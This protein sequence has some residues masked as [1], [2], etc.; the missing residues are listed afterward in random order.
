[1]RC[2]IALAAPL[3]GRR[4]R[5]RSRS[6]RARWR[7]P[8]AAAARVRTRA[9]RRARSRWRSCTRASRP[10]QSIARQ[11]RFVLPVRNVG[12]HTVPNVAVT[13]DSFDYTSD[14]PGL[15]ADKRPI[16]AIEQGPGAIATPP[17]ESQ[18]VSPPGGGQTAYVNTWALGALAPGAT[19]TFVW[20]VVPVKAGH[21][22]RPLH[23]RSRPRGQGEGAA[24]HPAASCRG[25]SPSTSPRRP[26]AQA[27]QPEHGPR[28]SR[29]SSRL[30]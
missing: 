22:H 19:R 8:A 21:V 15:A 11:T 14:Y 24:R 28:R 12:T 7:W 17:V 23:R 27:R 2:R 1:M 4:G 3:G 26:P 9:K 6:R 16:W 5:P 20:H 29:R 18:E 13:I 10:Q 30:P 25:S